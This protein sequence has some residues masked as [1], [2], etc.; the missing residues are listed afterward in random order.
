[1]PVAPNEPR[2]ERVT[3]RGDL[4]TLQLVEDLAGEVAS[5]TLAVPLS[6]SELYED[7]P[8]RRDPLRGPVTPVSARR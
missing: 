6:M 8:L 5:E 1:M 2:V 7:V 4:S 3:H